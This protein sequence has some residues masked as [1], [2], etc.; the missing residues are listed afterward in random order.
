MYASNLSADDLFYSDNPNDVLHFYNF[1]ESAED[2]IEWM[3]SRPRAEVKIKEV[4]G[5]TSIIIVIPT[6]NV[7]GIYAKNDIEI[8]KGLHIIFCESSGRYFNYAHSINICV[9][10]AMKYDPEWILFSNDDMYKVDEPYVLKNELQQLNYKKVLAVLP[11]DKQYRFNYNEIRVLRPS[12]IKGY[13][14]F[15]FGMLSLLYDNLIR[16]RNT[17]ININ[18]ILLLSIAQIHYNNILRK[19][20]LP[21]VDLRIAENRKITFK[22]RNMMEKIFNEYINSFYIKKFGDFGGFSRAFLQ[23]RN[24]IIFDETYINGVENYD[25][26]FELMLENVPINIIKYRKGSYK[27]RS[28]GTGITQ[29]GVSRSIRQFANY[30]YFSYK[31]LNIL[32]NKNNHK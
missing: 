27:G 3:R 21:F 23:T 13:R 30:I 28:L 32:T 6:A 9:K 2:L 19:F 22:I 11:I 25:L 14:N 8:Y 29:K 17:K 16:R 15:S 7:N 5:D 26:S 20:N 12:I 4:E 1:F 18:L 31:Y 24:G 10:E